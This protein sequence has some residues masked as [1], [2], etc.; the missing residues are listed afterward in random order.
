MEKPP[1]LLPA[2]TTTVITRAVIG[3]LARAL[4]VPGR[5]LST[6]CTV[7]SGLRQGWG[8]R[9]HQ[10][11]GQDRASRSRALCPT[12]S[13]SESAARPGG[14]GRV[15]G[16]PQSHAQRPPSASLAPGPGRL[17]QFPGPSPSIAEQPATE[18]GP[19]NR[20][21]KRSTCT[22]ARTCK[23]AHGDVCTRGACAHT[24][25]CAHV[26]V[27]ARTCRRVHIC[28]YVRKCGTCVYVCSYTHACK[29]MH[30]CV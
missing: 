19:Q 20:G 8:P 24:C 12:S 9:G 25:T 18:P 23:H 21:R 14:T 5:E 6:R 16:G 3:P 11:G 10:L 22:H 29:D 1:S 15:L 28:R 7:D 26:H 4:P 27:W 2:V 13:A 30:T 17:S